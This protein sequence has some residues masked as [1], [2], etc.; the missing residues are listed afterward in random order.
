M[1]FPNILKHSKK[2]TKTPKTPKT[3]FF[4]SLYLDKFPQKIYFLI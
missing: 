1:E 4:I 2:N 3:Q